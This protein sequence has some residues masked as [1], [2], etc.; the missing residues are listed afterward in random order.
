M[1]KKNPSLA[2]FTSAIMSSILTLRLQ[3]VT[4]YCICKIKYRGKWLSWEKVIWYAKLGKIKS[5]YFHFN[6]LIYLDHNDKNKLIMKLDI[7]QL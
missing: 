4:L 3:A 5:N 6:V 7:L 2:E 1:Y